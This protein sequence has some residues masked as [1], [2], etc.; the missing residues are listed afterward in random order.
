MFHAWSTYRRCTLASSVRPRPLTWMA[1]S[2][3]CKQGLTL[4]RSASWKAWTSCDSGQIRKSCAQ[5]ATDS[6][7]L[8]NFMHEFP[9][10]IRYLCNFSP[11]LNLPVLLGRGMCGPLLHWGYVCEWAWKNAPKKKVIVLTK[12]QGRAPDLKQR[13]GQCNGDLLIRRWPHC[14]G[15]W[16]EEPGE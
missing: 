11:Q 14:P 8:N 13:G 6:G 2:A 3:S 9:L 4:S 1:P 12:M 10:L 7:D 5:L 15:I 16:G